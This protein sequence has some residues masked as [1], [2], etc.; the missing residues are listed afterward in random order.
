MGNENKTPCAFECAALTLIPRTNER[1]S[2]APF[3]R[4]SVMHTIVSDALAI[5]FC[6]IW[7]EWCQRHHNLLGKDET[8][9]ESSYI[10]NV[11]Y[12][13]KLNLNIVHLRS[14]KVYRLRSRCLMSHCFLLFLDRMPARIV[15]M[16]EANIHE[17]H[18]S[19]KLRQLDGGM[20]QNCECESDRDINTNR[21]RVKVNK[22]RI[23]I[24]FVLERLEL[25]A[26]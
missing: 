11:S 3:D 20:T 17:F 5:G 23:L 25:E 13:T 10:L 22:R 8:N 2:F 7:I 16:I 1:V 6:C 4:I 26:E 21:G 18:D 14:A 9:E 15:W 24:T 12:F 19:S